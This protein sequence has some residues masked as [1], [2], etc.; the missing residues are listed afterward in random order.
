MANLIKLCNTGNKFYS[1]EFYVKY[2]AK[3]DA[4]E[5]WHIQCNASKVSTP[6]A[7]DKKS[8]SKQNKGVNE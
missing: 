2:G 5:A 4:I 3:L 6:N 8:V 1:F 7:V